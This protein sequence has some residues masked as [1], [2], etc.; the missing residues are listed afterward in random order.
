MDR[1]RTLQ[2]GFVLALVGVFV[3]SVSHVVAQAERIEAQIGPLSLA[4][5]RAGAR[6]AS[7]PASSPAQQVEDPH[8]ADWS[9]V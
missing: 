7:E 1:R 9:R 3:G 8:Q 4:A 6:L 5:M 2:S